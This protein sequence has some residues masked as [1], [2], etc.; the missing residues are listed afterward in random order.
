MEV[1]HP[2]ASIKAYKEFFS[3]ANEIL[4]CKLPY[5]LKGETLSYEGI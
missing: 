1:I 4:D 2:L 5:L 3:F